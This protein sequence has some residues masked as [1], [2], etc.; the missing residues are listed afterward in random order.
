VDLFVN[1]GEDD[2]DL[3]PG[4]PAIDRGRP[5]TGVDDDVEGVARSHGSSIDIGAYEFEIEGPGNNPPIANAGPDAAVNGGSTVALNG[6]ASRDPDGDVLSF[7]WTQISGPTVTLQGAATAT[8]TFTAP[9]VAFDSALTFS[10]LVTDSR[11]GADT[12]AVIINVL[13]PPSPL[14][15]VLFPDGGERFKV[16]SKK[17]IQWRADPAVTGG[18]R[19]DLSRDGGQ[20]FEVIKPSVIAS[21]GRKNWIV[22]GPPTTNAVIRVI[23]LSDPRVFGLSPQP[24]EIRK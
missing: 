11:G 16:G 24:F 14:I 19:I 15:E 6:S 13:A 10:L 7:A 22:S 3:R 17:K 21:R 23:S 5:V 18:V 12:D 4:S 9:V 2:Y 8:P 20:T 1:A